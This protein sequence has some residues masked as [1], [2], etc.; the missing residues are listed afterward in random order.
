M[1]RHHS[2]TNESVEQGLSDLSALLNDQLRAIR[3]KLWIFNTSLDSLPAKIEMA[4]YQSGGWVEREKLD[5]SVHT[6]DELAKDGVV[7]KGKKVLNCWPT[8]WKC[9]RLRARAVRAER[10][11]AVAIKSASASLSDAFEALLQY[12]CAC[13]KAD[14][15]RRNITRTPTRRDCS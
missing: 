9:A 5:R 4:Y 6:C 11:A 2:K 13:A 10:H 12:A 14:E 3:R 1:E 15:Y 8:K 7:L